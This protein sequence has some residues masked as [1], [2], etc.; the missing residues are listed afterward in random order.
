M[1][2][3]FGLW[4][5]FF[6]IFGCFFE[7]YQVFPLHIENFSTESVFSWLCFCKNVLTLVKFSEFSASFWNLQTL[8]SRCT[9]GQKSFFEKYFL[10][11]KSIVGLWVKQFPAPGKKTKTVRVL[12]SAFCWASGT[13]LVQNFFSRFLKKE[14]YMSGG[15]SRGKIV[16][17]EGNNFF[18]RNNRIVARD[19][20]RFS[21]FFPRVLE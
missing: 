15:C 14:I 3:F 1:C 21:D 12:I 7:I 4:A 18:H 9:M 20:W 11:K 19:F 2:K 6:W 8:A 16:V 5:K 13:Y 17:F 10:L